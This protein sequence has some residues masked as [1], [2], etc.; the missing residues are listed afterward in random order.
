M[1]RSTG[2]GRMEAM[3]RPMAAG[4]FS[5]TVAEDDYARQK[6][7]AAYIY[8]QL[9]EADEANL[10]SEED[11][12]VFGERPMTDPL[13]LVRCNT[14]KKPIKDSQFAA[15]AELCR[16]L[17]LTVQ[18]GLE[19]NGNTRNRKPPRNDKKKLPA[20]SAAGK[21]RKSE[22]LDNI[23]TVVSQSHLNSQI[24]GTSF[25]NDVKD[26][27]AS[28]LDD[29]G[30]SCGNRVLQASVMYPPTK[31]NKLKTSTHISVID[32]HGTETGVSK[33]A[34]LTNGT[35][36][37][38]PASML[39]DT[40][41][42][43]GSRVLQASVM[44]PPTKRH[45]LMASTYVAAIEEH[46]TESGVSKA[47]SL[48]N[49]TTRKDMTEEI[50]SEP[51]DPF[52]KNGQQVHMQRQYMKNNDFPAPL[53]TK[54]YYSQRTNR[55]RAAIRH[56]YFESL[57]EEVRADVECPK[58]S[59]EEM[60]ALQGLSQVDPSFEQME[61]VVN[62][63]SHLGMMYTKNSDDILAKS[64]E[65]C[66]LKAGGVPSDGLS[67]QF[68]LDNVSRSAAT[69]VGLT[70]GSFL[71]KAYSFPT[72]TGNRLETLQQPNGSVPVI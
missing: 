18:T 6:S 60:V 42:T 1:T 56:M 61:N 17:K 64:S 38:A 59:N 9:R 49:G 45:K 15:H 43:S 14:C 39:D 54:I 8:R 70:R 57:S 3:P 53:A 20:S 26:A 44:Y 52:H 31:H 29:T 37:A 46:G 62:K 69:H 51:G 47:A 32:E 27:A 63:E 34:S 68:F 24:R 19:L 23:D 30:V 67:N 25:S 36:H 40:G 50:V 66:L 22:S 28:M 72:N 16:S 35:T 58:T 55:L 5:Q 4:G 65:V 71:P 12:H 13:K 33:A 10:L 11:M 41:V 2:S 7:A 48:T 21:R